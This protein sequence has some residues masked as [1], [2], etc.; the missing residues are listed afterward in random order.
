MFVRKCS[1]KV[2]EQVTIMKINF[3]NHQKLISFQ[4]IFDRLQ[5]HT[6]PIC[7]SKA[8]CTFSTFLVNVENEHPTVLEVCCCCKVKCFYK[9]FI[10][11]DTHCVVFL[12]L[13]Y[14]SFGFNN[15]SFSASC[16]LAQNWFNSPHGNTLI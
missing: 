10:S 13:A 1:Q 15:V 9:T 16:Y 12:L 3:V 14:I 6:A 8:P 5:L 11:F 2:F 7:C 4:S